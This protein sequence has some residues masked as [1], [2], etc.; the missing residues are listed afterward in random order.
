MTE[1][2]KFVYDNFPSLSKIGTLD[3]YSDYLANVYPDSKVKDILYR[4]ATDS[5]YKMGTNQSVI[6]L[7]FFTGSINAANK[8]ADISAKKYG[9]K[10]KTIMAIVNAENPMIVDNVNEIGKIINFIYYLKQKGLNP[11][12]PKKIINHLDDIQ[13]VKMFVNGFNPEELKKQ[14]PIFGSDLSNLT[15]DEIKIGYEYNGSFNDLDITDKLLKLGYDSVIVKESKDWFDFDYNQI[16]VQDG[17]Y[18]V[19]GSSDDMLGFMKFL[20]KHK[21]KN[22]ITEI[23]NLMSKL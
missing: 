11:T 23:K 1:T 12:D 22:Q 15:D 19:L 6:N 10:A 16:G 17:E 21:L 2:I 13:N 7:T 9:S 20:G 5:S 8:Y 14:A 4:G 3:E 18:L